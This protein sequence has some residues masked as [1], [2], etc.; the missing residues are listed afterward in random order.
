MDVLPSVLLILDLIGSDMSATATLGVATRE[1]SP[2]CISKERDAL[3]DFKAYIDQDPYDLLSTWATDEEATIDCC[4][5]S[6]VTCNNQTGHVTSIDLSLGDLE[7]K[8]SPSLLN[9]SY[10]NSLDL[11]GNSFN[12]TI[13]MLNGSMTKLWYLDLSDN[14]FTGHVPSKLENLKNLQYLSLKFLSNCTIENID[15]LSHLSRLQHLELDGISLAKANHWINVILSFRKLSYLSLGGC[16]L[17]QVMYPYSS[18]ANFNSSSILSLYL[19]NNNLS[20]SMYQWLLPLTNNKLEDFDLSGNK[21]NGIPKY[22]GNM[23]SLTSLFF[24]NNSMLVKL[25]DFL[26]NLSGCTSFTLRELDASN[27][28]FTGSL[29]DDIQEFSSLTYLYLQQNQLN[30]TMSEKVW[31]LPKLA[32][33]DVS[34]NSLSVPSKAQMSNLSNVEH[35]ALSSC[36]LGPSFPTWIQTLKNLTYLDIANTNISDTIPMDFWHTW[37]TRLIHMDLSSNN[38]TGEVTD[39]SPNFK[40]DYISRIRI[41]L[42]SN[43]FYGSIS[44]VP[45][46][47]EWLDLSKNQLHGGISFLCQVVNGYLSFLDLSNNLLSGEI[48]DCLWNFKALK[49]LNLGQNNLSRKLPTSIKYLTNLEVLYLY[50]NN[51]SGELPLSLKNCSK[52]FYL[53][54]GANKFYGHVPVWIG[55]SLS[56]L[57][58]LSLASNNFF[59]TIPLQLCQLAHLRILDLSVN[60]LYGTIPLC[61]KNLTAMVQDGASPRENV[62]RFIH[63]DM[64]VDHALIKWKGCI[65]EF[66]NNL[67]FLRYIDLSSNNLIGKIP[68]GLADLHELIALNLSM[69]ALFG[70]IP[71][72]IGKIPCSTQLQSFEPSRYTG[73]PGLCGPPLTKDCPGEVTPLVYESEGRGEGTNDLHRWYYI[74]GVSGFASGFCIA[75]G[76][77]LVNWHGRRTFFHFLDVSKD[78]IYVKVMAFIAK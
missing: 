36:K 69:N 19:G 70:E 12:G 35:I 64:Y 43:N 59:G 72:N 75:C 6:G 65:R 71:L 27:S 63:G 14:Y 76:A 67:E 34:S 39:L 57:Y 40:P 24:D 22:I 51:L 4:D 55:E 31:Q 32:T 62:H 45:S 60:N 11:Q 1:A 18:S 13:P 41:D 10:L 33:L 5:W 78:W 16:N 56:E 37:P 42:S 23:C 66:N 58:A 77:L 44:Y 54:L 49:V 9:L 73:N 53:E 68:Y 28:Q 52:L 50:N 20:S 26:N 17:W 29:S 38:I 48:P 2:K 46:N 74:G 30:G 21:L 61:F 15:R 7:G 25:P 3:L 47:L 8:I